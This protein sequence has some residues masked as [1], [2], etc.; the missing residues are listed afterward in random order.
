MWA[1]DFSCLDF[2][3]GSLI[4][5]FICEAGVKG[6]FGTNEGLNYLYY[7]V[8][9]EVEVVKLM[10]RKLIPLLLKLPL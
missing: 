1:T 4:L 10:G 6:I 9:A 3:A 5:Q 2:S 8:N 7:V